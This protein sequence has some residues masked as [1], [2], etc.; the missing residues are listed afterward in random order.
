MTTR[1]RSGSRPC[2]SRQRLPPRSAASL[3]IGPSPDDTDSGGL[4][5]TDST[6]HAGHQRKAR[7]GTHAATTLA[8]APTLILDFDGVIADT[9]PLHAEAKRRT[10]DRFGIAYEPQL[11]D[12]FKGRTDVDFFA[13]VVAERTDRPRDVATL[14]ADK[15]TKYRALFHDVRLM[16]GFEDFLAIARARFDHIAVA[17]SAS[18]EDFD[19]VADRFDLH[20]ALDVIVTSDD[21]TR[22]KPDS[23][24]YRLAA[25]RL[26]VEAASA[27]V[28]EY[29]PNGVRSASAAG[30]FVIG[31]AGAFPR[32]ALFEAGADLV[33]DSLATLG[34]R[35]TEAR[36]ASGHFLDRSTGA[37]RPS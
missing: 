36:P 31:L 15:R 3:L 22:F 14:L 11:F 20:R 1:N 6:P 13:H 27:V 32:A 28:V 19:L 37:S 34:S 25:E 18:R 4:P 21:T 30:A 23:E 26:G 5:L 2:S 12:D 17:T 7:P 29:S 10:L 9:E 16:P 33:V 35:L 24:P 8:T